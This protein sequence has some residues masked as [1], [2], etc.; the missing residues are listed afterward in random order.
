MIKVLNLHF[1]WN[2]KGLYYGH[3]SFVTTKTIWQIEHKKSQAMG[4]TFITQP[5]YQSIHF[6][7]FCKMLT[8]QSS[9]VLLS[10]LHPF[11][12]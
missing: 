10:S 4:V 3:K 2:M 1:A 9:F 5:N 6:T 12:N 8:S 7:S 11:Y